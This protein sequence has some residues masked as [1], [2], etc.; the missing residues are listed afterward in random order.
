M[1]DEKIVS[2]P[3]LLPG[4]V[5][6]LGG[7]DYIIP[8]L[9]IKSLKKCTGQIDKVN[10]VTVSNNEKLSIV[11]EI[12]HLAIKRNYKE[13]TM[14]FMEEW[15]DLRNCWEVFGAIMGQSGFKEAKPG[16]PKASA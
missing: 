5:I 1:A 12:A 6:V 16:E 3:G 11:A 10:D 2:R 4:V 15:I 13:V 9:N 14:E 8:A 7:Q